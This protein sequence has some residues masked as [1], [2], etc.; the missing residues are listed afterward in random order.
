M[1]KT[2]DPSV[3]EYDEAYTAPRMN[4]IEPGLILIKNVFAGVNFIDTNVRKGAMPAK[5][6]LV[7]GMEGAGIVVAA[8]SEASKLFPSGSRVG[9]MGIGV[10]SYAQFS[11][12][13]GAKCVP[14]DDNVPF[15]DICA[16]MMGG[17]T[18]HYLVSADGSYE[19]RAGDHV[20]IHAGAGGV[21]LALTQICKAKG[22][23]VTTTVSTKTKAEKS[24]AAGAAKFLRYAD[25]DGVF[26]DAWVEQARTLTGEKNGFDVVY[27][28]VGKAT[29]PHSL[30]LVAKCGTVVLFGAASGAPDPI[31][32]LSL[33]PK[34]IKLT[35]P[36]LFHY[37][38]NPDALRR[39]AR[40]V[41]EWIATGLIKFDYVKAPLRDAAKVHER[42]EGR[43]TSGKL[44]L[45]I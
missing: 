27:D 21:G 5:L 36:M 43:Q 3:I 19:V 37:V 8:G 1:H 41:L 34:S 25:D 28:S 24:K 16:A 44:L 14:V 18:T 12:V 15:E 6:P 40:D 10:Q 26:G 39:R 38:A 20:L 30:D 17:M 32:P 2:G 23:N 29:F 7:P 22:A 13:D 42:L 9:Y 45:E 11:L 31:A 4:E 35:R 33:G